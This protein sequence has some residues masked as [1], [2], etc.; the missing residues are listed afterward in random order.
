MKYEIFPF[1]EL[2]HGP[3]GELKDLADLFGLKSPDQAKLALHLLGMKKCLAHKKPCPLGRGGRLGPVEKNHPLK[4]PE[5]G[6]AHGRL[7]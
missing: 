7:Y 4:G 3:P 6:M 5:I 1:R 2:E